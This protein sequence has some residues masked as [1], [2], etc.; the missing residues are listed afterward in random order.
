MS[1]DQLQRTTYLRLLDYLATRSGAILPSATTL[2]AGAVS[3]PLEGTQNFLVGRGPE[4]TIDH[5]F[6]HIV[7][8]LNGQGRGGRYYGF[9]TGGS[10]PV[11]EAADNI[12][13]A[14]DQNV[15]AHLPEHSISTA[16]EDAALRM[17]ISLLEL[18]RPVDW[19]G[20]TFTTGGTASNILGLACGRES[21]IESR[22]KRPSGDAV[23]NMGLLSACLAAG[24]RQIQILT[25]MAHS[26]LLKAASV[27]GLG[28][29]SVRELPA[30]DEEP[31]LLDLDAL[32]REL[33]RDSVASIIVI[34]AGEV[35][36]GRFA[37]NA[38][39]MPQVRSLADRYGAWVHVDG[40][41]S[42]TPGFSALILFPFSL[43]SFFFFFFFFFSLYIK[44]KE[45]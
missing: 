6:Q 18:G 20:R 16:V 27:V 24:V 23:A 38:L 9:V 22:L 14:L 30:S 10:L 1:T 42:S 7:P 37:T 2:T 29:D 11:A 28:H 31:W 45:L 39:Y 41:M 8:A 21:V 17:I 13:S 40:G 12:V 32:E 44:K 25:T 35:N 5:L 33:S 4:A 26:S 3:L 19:A 36:T 34:S 15:Q 43:F